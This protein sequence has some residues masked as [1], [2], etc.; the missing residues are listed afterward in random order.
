MLHALK[1]S[2][3]GK[4]GEPT[5]IIQMDSAPEWCNDPQPTWKGGPA[6][7]GT[8]GPSLRVVRSE[9]ILLDS[10]YQQQVWD[11]RKKKETVKPSL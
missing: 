9:L 5:N 2:S 10:R 11:D 4:Y 3:L 1:E 8:P 6:C 7:N